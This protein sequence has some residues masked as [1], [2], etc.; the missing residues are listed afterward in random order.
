[1]RLLLRFKHGA[2]EFTGPEAERVAS[3][4]LP[5]VNRWGG[6]KAEIADAVQQIEGAGDS[7]RYLLEASRRAQV[8]IKSMTDGVSPRKARSRQ[9]Q[10]NKFGLFSL[11]APQRLA[12]EMALHEES[13]RRALE[14]ELEELERAWQDAEEVAAIADNMFVPES[15]EEQFKKLKG[16]K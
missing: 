11:P 10:F 1:M 6:K 3:I 2:E 13:E 5:K 15:V 7:E 14:G 8:Y 16:E 9:M 12:L 4:I